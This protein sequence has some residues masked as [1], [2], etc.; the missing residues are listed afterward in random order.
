MG[1]RLLANMLADW[2]KNGSGFSSRAEVDHEPR[3]HRTAPPQA[4]GGTCADRSPAK[5]GTIARAQSG[6]MLCGHEVNK[7]NLRCGKC[8]T[9]S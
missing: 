3:D 9:I 5:C 2:L 7:A 6:N 1:G 4:G 8:N